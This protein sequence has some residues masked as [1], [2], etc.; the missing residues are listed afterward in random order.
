MQTASYIFIPNY[1]CSYGI[2][3]DGDRRLPKLLKGGHRCGDNVKNLKDMTTS[4]PFRDVERKQEKMKY[5]DV[6]YI[7]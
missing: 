2:D 3:S 6:P 4:G 1:F 5:E 7:N